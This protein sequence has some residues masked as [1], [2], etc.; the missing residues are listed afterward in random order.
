MAKQ[1]KITSVKG[2]YAI[3]ADGQQLRIIGNIRPYGYG[4]TD[5]RVVYGYSLPTYLSPF[6][7]KRKKKVPLIPIFCANGST[8]VSYTGV[9]VVYPTK[10]QNTDTLQYVF[11]DD[12]TQSKVVSSW[13]FNGPAWFNR[14]NKAYIKVTDYEYDSFSQ[15]YQYS[16]KYKD[17]NGTQFLQHNWKKYLLDVDEDHYYMQVGDYSQT[18]QTLA[19][20]LT[21]WSKR[22][23]TQYDYYTATIANYI[24]WPWYSQNS[25]SWY[26]E[27]GTKRNLA[28]NVD[29]TR[30]GITDSNL[31]LTLDN[32]F[33]ILL[34]DAQARQGSVQTPANQP[35]PQ[36]INIGLYSKPDYTFVEPYVD[37]GGNYPFEEYRNPRFRYNGSEI[38]GNKLLVWVRA[39]VIAYPLVQSKQG[40]WPV[41]YGYSACYEIRNGSFTEK[42]F[43]IESWQW[44]SYGS[45]VHEDIE[46]RDTGYELNFGNF[47]WHSDN[48]RVYKRFN[49]VSSRT[50][51]DVKGIVE[52]DGNVYVL[53][54]DTTANAT[55][56][57]LYT[58]KKNGSVTTLHVN[59]LVNNTR[60]TLIDDM[61]RFKNAYLNRWI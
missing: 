61:V 13:Y 12:Q 2:N 60:L 47:S 28:L 19:T 58:I 43:K 40:W 57:A 35:N 54:K 30:E 42:Y 14:K 8:P 48:K 32:I 11:W 44:E 23:Q 56:Y 34:Q 52:G 21:Y 37:D 41:F 24:Q 7:P 26:I 36:L 29:D 10:V 46:E 3:T 9:N 20:E 50:F 39:L 1:V 38:G 16:F 53:A 49:S 51:E 25:Y 5:G 59:D 6:V 55:G 18:T 33:T 27:P 17:E 15:S 45:L 22:N 4:Y 31:A